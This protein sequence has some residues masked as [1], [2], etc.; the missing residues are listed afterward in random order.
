MST[1]VIGHKNPDTDSICASLA[2]AYFKKQ[3]SGEEGFIPARCGNINPQTQFVLDK[4]NVLP[5]VYVSDLYIRARDIMTREAVYLHPQ[6][7]LRKAVELFKENE[8]HFIPI[9][10]DSHHVQGILTFSRIARHILQHENFPNALPVSVNALAQSTK[11]KLLVGKSSQQTVPV[12]LLVGGME[13]DAFSRHV[14]QSAETARP[15]VIVGDRHNIQKLAIE[16][17]VYAL[18]VSGGAHISDDILEL[19]AAKEVPIL[20]SAYDTAATAFLARLSTPVEKVAE[21]VKEF[22]KPEDRF[23]EIRERIIHAEERGLVVLDDERNLQGIVTRT[24]LLKG[25]RKQVVL[26]DHN[27]RSQAIDGIEEAELVEII[28]HHRLGDL[29]TIRPIRFINEPLGSTCTIITQFFH[30]MQKPPAPDIAGLLL[31]GILSDTML[32]KSPTTTP[33]D[34]DMACWLGEIAGLD[35]LR[36]GN[37]L[38]TASSS[39]ST[40]SAREIINNDFKVYEG[41]TGKFGIGQVEIVG[42]SLLNDLK[43]DL[44]TQLQAI[45]SNHEYLFSILMVSDVV[46]GGSYL[47]YAGK[48]Y[49]AERLGYDK[50]EQNLLFAKGMLSRKKQL[51][52]HVLEILK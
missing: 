50:I 12:R 43:S 22:I 10:A 19:A 28:D 20:L 30:R 47:L 49:L 39:I 8:F 26:V 17:G 29:H 18:L 5:P 45:T 16:L 36:F 21:P 7:P 23:F 34:Q 31:S 13:E 14:L 1:I 38:F 33:Y 37:D 25:Y 44:L 41:E 6:D 9:S 11:A 32:F 51:V 48:E 24:D 2:Y 52:P 35:I 3:I 40:L 42:R 15:V 4:F 27:E 46:K